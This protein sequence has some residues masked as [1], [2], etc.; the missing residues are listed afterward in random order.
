MKAY[1]L[2]LFSLLFFSEAKAQEE[3]IYHVFQ[4]SFFDSDGDTHGDLKGIHQKLDC[5]QEL[6][7]TSILLTPLYVSDFYHNYFAD[8][9]E[10]IDA[11]YGSMDDYLL[12]VKEIH[13][14][15]MKIY[16]D[17]EMQ[18][19]SGQHP[20]FK[21]SSNNPKSQFSDYLVYLDDANTQPWWFFNVPEFTMYNNQKQQ[22]IVVNMH[23]QK[24]KDYTKK[25]L[26]FWMD[27][28]KDGKFDDGVDGFRLDHMMDNL[29]NAG[30]L[31]NL[32]RDFWKP[33]LTDLKTVNPKVKIIAEQANWASF[34]HDYFEKGAVDYVFAFRLKFA[35]SNF[36][37]VEIE[38]AADST[39]LFNP[40]GKNQ[41]VFL[42]N[43]DTKR[44]ASEKEMNLAKSK[45][46]AAI[47]L[48]IGGIPSLYYGQEI[49]MK[50]VQQSFGMTDGNDIPVREAFEWYALDEGKG[51]A[52]WYKNTGI[53]WDK[54]S[55]K[56]NDGIS[57]E[58]QK[59][60]PESLW[61][62]YRKMFQLRKNYPE[63]QSGDYAKFGN[64]NAMVLS[65]SR[66]LGKEKVVVVV[67]LS[68]SVQEF[69]FTDGIAKLD[70]RY[71]KENIKVDGSKFQ[72]QPYGIVVF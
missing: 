24:V 19:V 71:G 67:N 53:W 32:F 12:L 20:W 3:V 57:F 30:K 63:L 27:P 66:Q 9:F 52:M 18:Y 47:Q 7:V 69:K 8:D 31:T 61:N 70:Y 29:D 65:F 45:A 5:L 43:H 46:A 13:K 2:L 26:L 16:Q 51:M 44:F 22:I 6:G 64:D 14:R 10:K 4:R 17:V 60:N 35:I 48:L 37:K 58:E 42:E 1:I 15:K 34:G 36:N 40:K 21:D 49:G 38:K 62:F 28:N 33:M 55:Q 59:N 11:E 39:L 41:L 72:I 25:L 50:G 54:R 56:P 23:E 68:E